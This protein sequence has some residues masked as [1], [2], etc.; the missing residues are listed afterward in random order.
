MGKMSLRSSVAVACGFVALAASIS[1]RQQT[2]PPIRVVPP[3]VAPPGPTAQ[4]I[5]T[6][7]SRQTGMTTQQP[8]TAIVGQVVDT[9]GR[10]VPQAA[11]RL[12]TDRILETVLTDP[13]GRFSFTQVPAGEM[14]VTAEKDGYF[15]GGYGQRRPTGLPLLFSLPYGQIMPNMKIE[16][17]RGSTI[18][19]SVR[20]EAG[21][22][23]IGAHVFAARRQ[24]KLGEWQYAGIDSEDTDDQGAFRIFGL[25]PGEYLVSV[26]MAPVAPDPQGES[27]PADRDKPSIFPRMYY[28]QA[29]DRTIALPVLLAAGDVR[30]GV[31]FTLPAVTTRRIVGRLIGPPAAIENQAVKLVP[32]D[33]AWN[34]DVAGSTIS[35]SDGTFVFDTVPEG[36]YRLQAG[37]VAARSW[38][39]SDATSMADAIDADRPYCGTTEVVL[40]GGDLVVPGI[41]MVLSAAIAGRVELEHRGGGAVVPEPRRIPVS[42]EPAEPGLS[43]SIQLSMAPGVPFAVSHLIPGRYFLRVGALPTG[44]S[45]RSI[46][47]GGQDALDQA[48]DLK[49]ADAIATVKLADRGTE[50]IGSVRDNRM[51]FA[52]GAAVII[53]PVGMTRET[54]APNRIRET[55]TSTSG[56]FTVRGLPPGEYAVIVIDEASAEGWQDERAL[57]R[58]MPLASRFVLHDMETLSLVL[59]MR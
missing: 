25:M 42:L 49:E 9:S 16:V 48:I 58:L 26:G 30:Y 13:K 53:L 38:S 28:P 18:T 12:V 22:P 36:Q 55:R 21:E 52:S 20:D 51:Q 19:G 46:D 17:Y 24:F 5:N 54:W 31:N 2:T 34:T 29:P 50:L 32:M 10:P 59:Q 8:L 47:V 41:E 39:S 37:N 44:W 33:A 35:Q 40:R 57:A 11:V 43:H 56:V 4:G 23:I 1:A 27:Q 14:F 45:L 7:T 6:Q 3:V 15:D